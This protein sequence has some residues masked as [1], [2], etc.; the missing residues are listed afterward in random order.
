MQAYF[1]EITSTLEA[2]P[3]HEDIPYTLSA[4]EA[5]QSVMEKEIDAILKSP[6][7]A[8]KKEEE[9]KEEPAQEP[10]ADGAADAEMKN[11]EAKP[12]AAQ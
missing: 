2:K 8:P 6:P 1:L 12:E 10:K 5:K 4:V 3:L 7:P 9:K 11:E